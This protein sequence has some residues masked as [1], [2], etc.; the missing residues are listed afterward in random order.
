MPTGWDFYLHSQ[1]PGLTPK[2]TR[3]YEALPGVRSETVASVSLFSKQKV[4]HLSDSGTSS[5]CGN[6]PAFLTDKKMADGRTCKRVVFVGLGTR[7]YDQN[8]IAQQEALSDQLLRLAAKFPE[9]CFLWNAEPGFVRGRASFLALPHSDSDAFPLANMEVRSCF[10]QKQILSSPQLHA[11]VSHGGLNSVNEALARGV[12]PLVIVNR[13]NPDAPIAA[14]MLAERGWG[15]NLETVLGTH[16]HALKNNA[17]WT[18]V[19]GHWLGMEPAS[20]VTPASQYATEFPS[21]EKFFSDF[22]VNDGAESVSGKGYTLAQLRKTLDHDV[23]GGGAGVPAGEEQLTHMGAVNKLL[24]AIGKEPPRPT[25]PDDVWPPV[26]GGPLEKD[27]GGP[28]TAVV[29]ALV[30]GGLVLLVAVAL[31]VW[32]LCRRVTRS[33][34]EEDGE[35]EQELSEEQ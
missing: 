26:G 6:L 21:L 11:F 7:F 1:P 9:V 31:G 19:E 16:P 18:C 25:V 30:S 23:F 34:E 5:A 3:F 22:I 29:V 10:P 13:Q 27:G 4:S 12:P 2:E 14:E 20:S 17:G 15:L 33:S 28:S 32:C 8:S 24:A 35:T